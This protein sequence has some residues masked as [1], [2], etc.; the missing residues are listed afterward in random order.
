M[1]RDR[2]DARP[3]EIIV[4]LLQKQIQLTTNRC[5]CRSH[6]AA[7]SPVIRDEKEDKEGG[8]R[9]YSDGGLVAQNCDRPLAR[10]T[11]NLHREKTDRD[12]SLGRYNEDD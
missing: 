12:W 7:I 8:C 3:A 2:E 9:F 11:G 1:G 5:V 10:L 6:V 4:S